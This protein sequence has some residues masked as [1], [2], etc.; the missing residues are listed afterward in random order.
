MTTVLYYSLFHTTS[1][2]YIHMGVSNT[3][4]SHF[5]VGGQEA[6]HLPPVAHP[7]C[8]LVLLTLECNLS[9]WELLSDNP[10]LP[11]DP[12]PASN[13]QD[14]FSRA[15]LPYCWLWSWLH[16]GKCPL[17]CSLAVCVRLNRAN[18]CHQGNALT[19]SRRYAS[20][21]PNFQRSQFH[22]PQPPASHY[23]LPLISPPLRH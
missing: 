7:V 5:H 2:S 6:S 11:S 21:L 13:Q 12:M 1:I 4:S 23:M 17:R 20:N 16:R 14:A 22:L 8:A 18:Q 9:G 3:L 10:A 19:T 15:R